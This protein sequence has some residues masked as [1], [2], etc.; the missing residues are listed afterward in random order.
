LEKT[1]KI[2]KPN[3]Q[4][5]TTM[6]IVSSYANMTVSTEHMRSLD[7]LC[8]YKYLQIK[9]TSFTWRGIH[10]ICT[11]PCGSNVFVPKLSFS[12]CHASQLQ[13]DFWRHLA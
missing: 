10:F 2:N 8:Y 12:R 3:R 1:S 5:I 9:S 7:N 4:P 6:P 13:E 11:S